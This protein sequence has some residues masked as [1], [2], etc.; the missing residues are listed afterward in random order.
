MMICSRQ[1]WHR[2]LFLQC[3]LV[4]GLSTF[5]STAA[6]AA[7]DFPAVYNSEPDRDAQPMDAE[8]AAASMTVPAGFKVNVFASEP[9]VQNPIAMTWDAR[10]RL[11]IAENYTYAERQ[12]RF[13]LSLRDRVIVLEDTDLDGVADKRTVF[14]DQVQMLTGIEVG[15]GGVWLMCPPQLL[16]IPDDDHDLVPDGPGEVVLDG[17]NVAKEN[18]HNFANGLRFGPDGWLYGRC[19]GSCP[20]RI[21]MP[22]N[23]DEDRVA[24][25]GGIWRVQRGMGFDSLTHGTTN[26]WGHDFNEF[27]D[28][29][30]TNTVNGHLWQIIP[31]AHYVRPFT[32]DPN[33]NVY[34]LIDTHADHWHFDTTGAWHESRAGAANAYGGGHAHCGA[35]I[36][37]GTQWPKEYRNR[38]LTL[39]L[40]GRRVNQELL[41]PHGSG[42]VASHGEDMLISADPFFRGMDLTTGPD[43]SVYVIDWSDTGE[44]HEHTGVHRT[45]GRVFRVTYGDPVLQAATDLYAATDDDLVE[46]VSSP[47]PWASQQARIELA[48]RHS[49]Q[50]DVAAV[51]DALRQRVVESEG[52]LACQNI[53]A[54]AA[55]V[56]HGG[57]SQTM[58]YVNQMKHRDPHVRS[59]AVRL[60]TAS[61]PLDDCYGPQTAAQK[62]NEQQQAWRRRSLPIV[63]AESLRLA[64][65]DSDTAVRLALA[66]TLQRLPIDDRAELA[67]ELMQHAQDA[68]DH[69]LPLLVWYGLMPVAQQRPEMLPP[70][71]IASRWPKTQRLIARSLAEQIEASPLSFDL[72]V[73]AM[74]EVSDQAS[75]N[76]LLLGIADGMKGRRQ[77]PLPASW[78]QFVESVRD[79]PVESQTQSLV[80]ELSV[81]FGDGRALEDVRQIVLDEK[82]EINL[83]RSALAALVQHGGSD[84]VEICLPLLGDARLNA[85]A[86]IGAAQSGERKVAQELVK[87]Y[88]NFRSPERPSVIAIL[89]SRPEFA[90]CLL[91]AIAAKTIPADDLTAFDVRQI[92]SFDKPELIQRVTQLWGEVHETSEAKQTQI[93][94]LKAAL[95]RT[96]LANANLSNGR[97]LFS[98]SCAKCH[99]LFGSGETIGPDLTGANRHDLDYVLENIVDPSA[100]L[101]KDY[102]MTNVVMSDGRILGG[103]VVRK[104]DATLTLQTQTELLTID[105]DEIEAT[106][107]TDLSPMPDGLL[108]HLTAE[109]VC[110]LVAYLMHAAQVPLP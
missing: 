44:C 98:Q 82:A 20:G 100:V 75:R 36:Y 94:A 40:H 45:S 5:I 33:P 54:L 19:G 39:N 58:F 10:G 101:S 11:W 76:N 67:G 32:L 7:D 87:R 28:G 29:F 12:Q 60:A 3:S 51:R 57:E 31:G 89:V 80:R 106:R 4:V 88:R 74:C 13:D 46:Q 41:K 61:L 25:E 16:F 17:F 70:V 23:R 56:P 91:D 22:G 63:T 95:N 30:F 8:Q 86:A 6:V 84:V 105:V 18:Y 97:L 65:H 2:F 24:I 62:Q 14:T 108:D 81:V 90:E 21:G 66:S 49:L 73:K 38:L 55:I 48:E 9:D 15:R 69:N 64:K 71:A 27:G 78:E 83:R 52:S 42:Y 1:K 109:E 110:N 104:T 92:R 43:G 77:A 102:R 47:N 96:K 85:L 72:L 53:T 79:M 107:A 26:P 35:M 59:W 68:K 99:R 34:E 50:R 37:R 103:L 93:V